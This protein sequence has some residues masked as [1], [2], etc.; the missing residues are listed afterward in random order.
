[1]E[2]RPVDLGTRDGTLVFAVLLLG[3]FAISASVLIVIL[4]VTAGTGVTH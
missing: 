2:K 3:I 4:V 1:M